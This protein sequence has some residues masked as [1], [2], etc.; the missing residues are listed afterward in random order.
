M[1]EVYEADD[2]ELN[3]HVALKL[4]RPTYVG[5]AEALERF[6][7]E[8][9]IARGINHPNVCR[10]FDLGTESGPEGPA[11]HFF[12]MELLDGETLAS[13][14]KREG[15]LPAAEVLEIAR[16]LAAGLQAI[17]AAQVLHRDISSGNIMLC[18]QPN[19][20]VRTVLTDFGLAVRA[21]LLRDQDHGIQGGTL[22]YS[23]PEQMAGDLPTVESDVYAFGAVIYE[24]MTGQPP[25]REHPAAPSGL[26]PQLPA[27]WDSVVLR[28]LKTRPEDR[29]R[30]VADAVNSLAGKRAGASRRSVIAMAAV[31]LGAAAAGYYFWP[32]RAAP[33]A[34]PRQSIAV[35]GFTAQPGLEYI[36][37][38]L[39]NRLIDTLTGI[40]GLR[41]PGSPVR[42]QALL[43]DFSGLERAARARTI[44]RG[45]VEASGGGFT[46]RIHQTDLE[47]NYDLWSQ[48]F[49]LDEPSRERINQQVAQRVIQALELPS[50]PELTQVAG[51]PITSDDAYRAYQFG[52]YYEGM[53]DAGS[54]DRAVEFYRKAVHADPYFAR[55]YVRLAGALSLAANKPLVPDRGKAAESTEAAL[56]A[57]SLDPKL[58]EAEAVL[59]TNEHHFNWN[60]EAAEEHFRR[61]IRLNPG[62]AETHHLYA[63][64]LS[65]LSRHDE[66]LREIAK[67]RDLD[68]LS[69]A[70]VVSQAFDLA[71]AGRNQE[72]IDQLTWQMETHPGF[73]NTY[74]VL[75]EALSNTGQWQRALEITQ[76]GLALS[77][78]ASFMLAA[79]GYYL[80]RLGRYSEAQADL[81]EILKL[82]AAGKSAPTEA[83]EVYSGLR[84][85]N[86]MF[87]WLERGFEEHDIDVT[88]LMVDPVNAWVRSDRRFHELA[89]KLRLPGSNP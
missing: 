82:Q 31:A 42:D 61:A 52:I 36:A 23:A 44:L 15:A 16:Q 65:I 64:L 48:T 59:G 12:T 41:V 55:G 26:Q 66:A 72:A 35:A 18:R 4:L 69:S 89:L 84:D 13:R 51:K 50:S 43:A 58:G 57:L 76:R 6:R 24:L 32:S 85:A 22:S 2:R 81:T 1:G 73:I 68:P 88:L 47:T 78:G 39:T 83:A 33:A 20:A 45:N 86:A 77:G 74:L 8:I 53:R 9:R 19:G 49:P 60:W 10:I 87:Y 37:A 79:H 46:V 34:I 27:H 63:N 3:V 67:A 30:T 54:L 29:F 71:R 17:H 28:C 38:G 25:A 75:A 14:V 40:P 80:G 62:S 56:R 11:R 70:L 21:D 7:A 5:S